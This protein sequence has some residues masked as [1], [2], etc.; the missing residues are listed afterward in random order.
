MRAARADGHERVDAAIERKHLGVRLGFAEATAERELGRIVEVL[1]R[2]QHER[3]LVDELVQEPGER[4]G[5]Q[6]VGRE[7]RDAHAEVAVQRYH[8]RQ[9][10]AQLHCRRWVLHR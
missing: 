10:M 6:Q 4:I 8:A 9:R 7:A 1:A 3:V 5:V 2:E